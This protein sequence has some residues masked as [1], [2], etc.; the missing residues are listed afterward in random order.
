MFIPPLLADL[1]D[2]I[3]V[4]FFLIVGAFWLI[5]QLMGQE[6]AKPKKPVPPPIPVAPGAPAAG[7]GPLQTEVADFLRRATQRKGNPQEARAQ[8]FQHQPPPSKKKRGEKSKKRGRD[9][10]ER[11]EV[12]EHVRAR[13]DTSKFGQRAQQLGDLDNLEERFSH[14]LGRLGQSEAAPQAVTAPVEEAPAIRAAIESQS[15]APAAAI[16]ELLRRPESVRQA[17]IMQEILKRPRQR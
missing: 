12:D 16:A 6:A 3:K 15:V 2:I 7:Q 17:I 11:H 5:K 4:V 14:E 10:Q 1:D 9:L 8:I 13:L